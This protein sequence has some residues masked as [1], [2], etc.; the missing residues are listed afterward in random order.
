MFKIPYPELISTIKEKSGLSEEDIEGKVKQKLEQLSGLISKEGAAH[1]VANELGIKLLEQPSGK[2]QIKNVLPGMRDVETHAKV[3]QVYELRQFK[4][5]EREGQVASALVG[6][7]TGAIRV[8]MWGNQAE[9]TLRLRSGDVLGIKGGYVKDNQGRKEIHLNEKAQLTINPPGV[10]IKE[11][12]QTQAT[13]SPRKNIKELTE[14]DRNV[15][16]LGTIVQ[17]FEPRFFEVDP[18]SGRR[19]RPNAE[20]KFLNE[21]GEEVTPDHSYVLNAVIDDGTES[22]RG[23]FFRDHATKLLNIDH[24]K[25][26]GYKDDPST[27][28]E[29]KTELLGTITKVAGKVSKNDMFDRLE[30]VARDVTINPNPEEELKR[31]E[32]Q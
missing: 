9:H 32:K 19:I 27:F 22:I 3:L 26:I 5:G 2:L 30:I 16:L 7:E 8:V 15:E 17:V 24:P 20:N 25:M 11:V 31:M 1:I 13:T 12:A 14:Q 28:E 29:M 6:D 23:V 10:E 4:S 18:D 21:K